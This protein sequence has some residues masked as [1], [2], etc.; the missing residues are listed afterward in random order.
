MDKKEIYDIWKNYK[1]ISIFGLGHVCKNSIEQVKIFSDINYILDNNSKLD[2]EFYKGIGV[3]KFLPTEECLREKILI[4]THYKEIKKEL[5]ELGLLENVDFC[6]IEKYIII[7]KWYSL[8]KVY[9]NEVHMSVTTKCTLNCHKCNMFMP[10]YQKP[11]H[12]N[13]ETLISDLDTL[14]N[15]VDEVSTLALLGGEP[16]LYPHLMELITYLDN[17]YNDRIGIIELVTN[18]TIIPTDDMLKGFK[19]CKIFFRISDYSKTVPYQDRLEK[20]RN[21]LEQ[22]HIPYYV[23]SSLNWLDFG[24]PEQPV[25]IPD[26]EIYQHMLDCAPVFKGLNDKKLYY[27]HIVWSADKCGIYK[28]RE[29]DYIDLQEDSRAKIVEYLLG[30]MKEPVSLCKYCAGCSSDNENVIPV[31]I[32]RKRQKD[33]LVD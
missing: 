1:T 25:C 12:L 18:G 23:N 21:T 13:L 8:S 9:V 3:K 7:M 17:R 20:L 33:Y 28:E 22:Y 26:Q 16:L 5:L 6:S 4:S 27:C 32:Q 24:F 30:I 11:F 14:F 31:G 29:T 10:E 2:G 15:K 19:K